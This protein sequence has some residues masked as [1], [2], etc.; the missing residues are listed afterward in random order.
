TEG[1]RP[2]WRMPGR[3]LAALVSAL[4]GFG[5]IIAPAP[6]FAAD[7]AGLTI[8]KSVSKP[9]VVPGETFNWV[10]EVGCSVLTE[11]CINAELVD[12]IPPEF[13]INGPVSVTPAPSPTNQMLIDISP[14]SPPAVYDPS[15]PG[16]TVSIDFNIPLA[17]P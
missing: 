10:I 7:T 5:T 2:A 1:S 11:E 4:V 9:S 16:Q 12:A 17:Q 15:G 6:A 3:V 14:A 8:Q 13:D